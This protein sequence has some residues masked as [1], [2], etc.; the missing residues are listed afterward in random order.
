MKNSENLSKLQTAKVVFKTD[1][2]EIEI[3][4]SPKGVRR[5]SLKRTSKSDSASI[6]PQAALKVARLAQKQLTQYLNGVRKEFDL[7]LDLQ[8]TPFQMKVWQ[9][10][11]AIPFGETRTYGE[12]AK[13][14]GNPKAARAV[15]MANNR[16]PIAIVVPC[17]RVVGSNGAL[18][19]Y[20]G[21]LGLKKSLLEIE[22]RD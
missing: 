2:A 21:G 9:Q 18:V 13:K 7:P 10:L 22:G 8:G 17:H 14:I 20:A 6:G 5:L 15:G 4:A 12:L 19:G 16:N 3:E 1:L 11:R